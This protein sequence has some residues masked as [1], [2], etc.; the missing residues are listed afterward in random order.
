MPSEAAESSSSRPSAE[1][2]RGAIRF[3][4]N[5]LDGHLGD[6][7]PPIDPDSSQEEIEREYPLTC[8]MQKLVAA[9]E[10]LDRTAPKPAEDVRPDVAGL[11]REIDRL[12]ADWDSAHGTTWGKLLTRCRSM[13]ESLCGDL[14]ASE[15]GTRWACKQHGWRTDPNGCVWCY[16]EGMEDPRARDADRAEAERQL[17]EYRADAERFFKIA[18]TLTGDEWERISGHYPTSDE[19]DEYRAAIDARGA[20]TKEV[21][22]G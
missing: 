14:L 2:V 16:M 7:D 1:D 17:A 13:I 20:S 22:R 3:A 15:R 6:T 5:A 18:K 19:P 8:A 10:I 12:M 9:A 4:I 11:V 21:D